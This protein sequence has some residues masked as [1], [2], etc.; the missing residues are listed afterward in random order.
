M[1]IHHPR[2]GLP[3]GGGPWILQAPYLHLALW[4]L[5][6][7]VMRS[8]KLHYDQLLFAFLDSLCTAVNS[9]VII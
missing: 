4:L 1:L 7:M 3:K 8:D 2:D 9:I 5:S 6:A